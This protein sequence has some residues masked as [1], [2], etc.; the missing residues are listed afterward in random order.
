MALITFQY[1]NVVR[2]FEDGQWTGLTAASVADRRGKIF[3]VN[4]SGLAEAVNATDIDIEVP[5]VVGFAATNESSNLAQESIT[6]YT[7]ALV[8]VGRDALSGLDIGDPVFLSD[9]DHR[10]GD[11]EGTNRVI[12]GTVKGVIRSELGTD[13][14]LLIDTRHLMHPVV[15]PA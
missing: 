11:A 2:Q 6:L 3:K 5:A 8:D 13:K 9:T 7:H 12:I 4:A 1:F 10:A 14:L 15:F